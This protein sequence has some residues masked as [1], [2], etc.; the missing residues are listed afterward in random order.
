[1]TTKKYI[2]AGMNPSGAEDFYLAFDS[3]AEA[4]Q[5]YQQQI[6]AGACSVSIAEVIRSTDYEVSDDDP[7][8]WDCGEWETRAG[9]AA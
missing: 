3:L 2:V 8:G 7:Y 5:R 6:D 1:M 4:E 9:G